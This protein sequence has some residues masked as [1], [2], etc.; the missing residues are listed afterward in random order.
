MARTK[1]TLGDG[2]RVSDYLSA[3]LLA[4]VYPPQL[5]HQLLDLH[6]VNSK[7][8]RSVSALMTT[9]YSISTSIVP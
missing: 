3:S 5:I 9:Y 2:I 4:R 1:A 7:R 8:Q 6:G